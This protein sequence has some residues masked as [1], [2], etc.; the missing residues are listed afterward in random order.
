MLAAFTTDKTCP[1]KRNR[2][3]SERSLA[4]LAALRGIDA[5][6][7]APASMQDYARLAEVAC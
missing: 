5:G 6:T 2:P 7:P 3:P 4:E 1:A